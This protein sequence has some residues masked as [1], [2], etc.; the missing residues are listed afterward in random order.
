VTSTNVYFEGQREA[1][2]NNINKA[3]KFI[4]VAVA[5]LTDKAL[6]EEL[7]RVGKNGVKIYIIL[8]D[9]EIN[10]EIIA[11][12]GKIKQIGGEF[13]LVKSEEGLMHHKF[14]VIDCFTIINGSYNWTYQAT[15]NHEDL[16]VTSGNIPL[17]ARYVSEFFRL[18]DQYSKNIISPLVNESTKIINRRVTRT[19]SK[20]SLVIQLEEMRKMRKMRK[21]VPEKY[22]LE[23][24][25]GLYE[26]LS[27]ILNLDAII[28]YSKRVVSAC[29]EINNST[30]NEVILLLENNQNSLSSINLTLKLT[31]MKIKR[32]N[33]LSDQINVV[34]SIEFQSK[35]EKV[36]K[37]FQTIHSAASN[38]ESKGTVQF[39]LDLSTLKQSTEI[40]IKYIEMIT[41]NK[42]NK[43]MDV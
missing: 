31:L 35:A 20:S 9:D 21:G 13:L 4:L 28:S 3:S 41:S 39:L 43:I 14:C 15:K 42:V 26:R 11:Q 36:L 34:N 7:L 25:G 38:I 27:Q 40:H 30:Q 12:S 37:R 5:W 8:N 33:V 29:R 23:L 24:S 10:S 32:H 19:S 16:T 2:L 18:R 17:A 6:F 22:K 1:I